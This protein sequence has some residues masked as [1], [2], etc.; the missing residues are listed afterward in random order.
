LTALLTARHGI[1]RS[2]ARPMH[3]RRPTTQ[4]LDRPGTTD[5]HG[6]TVARLVAA[7]GPNALK[8]RLS[9]VA[10]TAGDEE[11]L[12]TTGARWDLS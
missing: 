4:T 10:M 6:H 7:S 3:H 5:K 1:G 11:D 8:G 9:G 2:L 12:F